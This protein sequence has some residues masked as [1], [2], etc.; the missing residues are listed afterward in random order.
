METFAEVLEDLV[1]NHGLTAVRWAEVGNEPNAP[2]GAVTLAEYNALNR[3][4]DAQLRA[5]GLR[6]QI[7]LMGGGLVESAG[8]RH[9]YAWMQWIAANMG[10]VFDAYAQHVYWWYDGSGRLE[11]RLRDSVHLMSRVLPPEQRKPTYMME[12]GIRGY[13]SCP[14]K[15]TL[16]AALQTYYRDAACTDIWRTNIAAFQQ[17][18]L[19]EEGLIE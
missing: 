10:D 16:P 1:R 9:H 13:N 14:G 6:E 8:A 19:E 3:A 4:L 12:F 17:E 2:N 11:Y 5:R 15:P 7:R 18:L